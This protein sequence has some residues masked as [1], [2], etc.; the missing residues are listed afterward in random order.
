MLMAL[1]GAARPPYHAW[2]RFLADI[3]AQ[4]AEGKLRRDYTLPSTMTSRSRGSR[5][6]SASA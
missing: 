1:F 5:A 6:A 2:Q 4:P 3:A